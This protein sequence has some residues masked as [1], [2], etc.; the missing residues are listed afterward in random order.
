MNETGISPS[1]PGFKRKKIRSTKK[2]RFILLCLGIVGLFLGAG[3][4][5][6]YFFK[7]IIRFF[8]LGLIYVFCSLALLAIRGIL[9][10]WEE[11]RKRRYVRKPWNKQPESNGQKPATE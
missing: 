2:L 8:N 7:G 6:G 5:A 9:S 10:G 3:L 1:S 11:L 4:F